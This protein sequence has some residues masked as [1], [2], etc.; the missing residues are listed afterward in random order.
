[1][2]GTE[3]FL[4]KLFRAK[5]N[6]I[7]KF[8]VSILLIVLQFFFITRFIYYDTRDLKKY[9]LNHLNNQT[10]FYSCSLLNAYQFLFKSYLF[11][12]NAYFSRHISVFSSNAPPK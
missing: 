1:M 12:D 4:D 11:N 9:F 8:L 5:T 3:F 7:S 6:G 10:I 2:I